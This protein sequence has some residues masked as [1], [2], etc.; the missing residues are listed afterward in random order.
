MDFRFRGKMRTFSAALRKINLALCAALLL[1]AG[2]CKAQTTKA[3]DTLSEATIRRIQNEIRSRYNVRDDIQMAVSALRE[4][5]I[6]GFDKFTVVFSGGTRTTSFDFL[7]SKDRKKIMR[8]EEH[9]SE[10]QSPDHLVCRL[11]L[12]KKKIIQY[13]EL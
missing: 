1:V 6:P 5:D 8:S 11:L 7:I 12:E 4:S 13:N 3:S 9:T 2:G 10:L